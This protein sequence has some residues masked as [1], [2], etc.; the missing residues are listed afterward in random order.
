VAL[1]HIA[2]GGTMLWSIRALLKPALSVIDMIPD[3]HRTPALAALRK[4]AQDGH[5]ASL[6]LSAEDR[7]LAFY[8]GHVQLVSPIGARLLRALY[9]EGRLKLKKPPQKAL[10][11]L[12]AF[13]ATEADFRTQAAALIAED[14]A[15]RTR[16]AEIVAN[17]SCARKDEITPFLIDKVATAQLGYAAYGSV[18]IAGLTCHKTLTAPSEQEAS[19]TRAEA[20]VLCWW[21]DAAGV[22]QGDVE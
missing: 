13:I 16:M 7:D 20:R 2:K 3:I 21:I 14:T 4:A 5:T 10:P 6:R 19:Q 12:D 17:P 15:Q 11:K 18:Q 8:D 9:T 22:R 1:I